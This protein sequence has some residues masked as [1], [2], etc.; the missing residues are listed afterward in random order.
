MHAGGAHRWC[1]RVGRR[2]V[3]RAQQR[4]ALHA[5][6]GAAVANYVC[7]SATA[8]ALVSQWQ[9][10]PTLSIAS[11]CPRL[12][13]GLAVC[14]EASTELPGVSPRA[15]AQ[16]RQRARTE[17]LGPWREWRRG[18]KQQNATRGKTPEIWKKSSAHLPPCFCK[19]SFYTRSRSGVPLKSHLGH[20]APRARPTAA[21]SHARAGRPSTPTPPAR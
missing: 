14:I 21:G 19:R 17:V 1:S 7:A 11:E 15:R 6:L 8:H 16:A 20:R 2:H 13:T 12:G 9:R 5:P 18:G 3:T 4:G 10:A